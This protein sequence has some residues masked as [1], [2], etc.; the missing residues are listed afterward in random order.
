MAAYSLTMWPMPQPRTNTKD[1]L[2][3]WPDPTPTPDEVLVSS[4]KLGDASAFERLIERHHHVCMSKAYAIL[5]NHGDA[6]DE[7]Q[8]AWAKAWKHLWQYKGEGSFA[9]WLG[10]IVSN[11]CLMRIREQKGAR[12]ISVDEVIDSGGSSRRLE[13]IDQ[14]ALP[15]QEV[16]EGQVLRVLIK[17]IRGI[18]PLLREPLVMRDLRQLPMRDIAGQLGISVPAA[19]SRLMRARLELKQRLEKHHGEHGCGTLFQKPASRRAA[20]VRAE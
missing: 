15:E 2:K 8:S 19:K 9:G 16:G 20:Y 7:V 10:S 6:E 5:R 11:Q 13:V 14:R 3:A 12:M 4:A 1:N 18:P 17:E